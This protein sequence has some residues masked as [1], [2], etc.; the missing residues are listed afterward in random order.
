M[1]WWYIPTT[2]TS[3]SAR[4]SD[5]AT[6]TQGVQLFCLNVYTALGTGVMFFL[7]PYEVLT[8]HLGPARR[9]SRAETVERNLPLPFFPPL[10]MSECWLVKGDG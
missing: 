2:N 8:A 1:W 3:G 9:S 4:T 6:S 10:F 7:Q 5:C